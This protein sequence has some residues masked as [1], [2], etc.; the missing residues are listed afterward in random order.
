MALN[1]QE[2]SYL[3]PAVWDMMQ[4]TWKSVADGWQGAFVSVRKGEVA[5]RFVSLFSVVEGEVDLPST[6]L[7]E[8]VKMV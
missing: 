7:P 4:P 5:T 6:F 2:C 3:R 1:E 8:A